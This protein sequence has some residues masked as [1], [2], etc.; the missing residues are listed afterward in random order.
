MSLCATTPY[1]IIFVDVEP[2]ARDTDYPTNTAFVGC[3]DKE[4]GEKA[5]RYVARIIDRRSPNPPT[6]LVV[7][8]NTQLNRQRQFVRVLANTHPQA[9]VIVDEDG[10]F[11]RD[12]A[13]DIVRRRLA[14]LSRQN[15]PV[16]VIFC[17]S[18][19]MALGALD[20]LHAP[21]AGDASSR[22]RVVGVDGTREARALINSGGSPLCATVVQDPA[23]VAERA[24][25]LMERKLRGDDVPHRNHLPVDLY[26]LD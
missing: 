18:D 17:T 3:S 8:A 5:G 16:D 24:V 20:A 21:D 9:T 4:I 12:R 11:A 6:V 22:V 26:A 19:E 10:L 25:D 1:P 7:A 14:E 13:R 2:F 23:R 15:R